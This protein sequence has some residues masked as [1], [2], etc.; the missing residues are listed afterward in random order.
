MG[1]GGNDQIIC[2][3][4]RPKAVVLPGLHIDNHTERSD[5]I[6]ILNDGHGTTSLK[7]QELHWEFVVHFPAEEPQLR[8]CLSFLQVDKDSHG[9]SVPYHYSNS[10]MA[11]ET[12]VVGVDSSLLGVGIPA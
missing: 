10:N 3:G 9:S 7:R 6:N 8:F 1:S 2:L 5:D 11:A 4:L 12:S